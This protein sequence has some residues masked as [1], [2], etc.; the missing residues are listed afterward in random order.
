[1]SGWPSGS[2]EPALEK[3]TVSGA[4]LPLLTSTEATAVGG[5]LAFRFRT[6]LI[7]PALFDWNGPLST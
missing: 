4:V 3:L 5:W 1:V 6:R 7:E 2:P